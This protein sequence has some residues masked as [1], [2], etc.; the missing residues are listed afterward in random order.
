[1][2]GIKGLKEY[3]EKINAK[4]DRSKA[5]FDERF[6]KHPLW[7]LEGASHIMRTEADRDVAKQAERLIE[8]YEKHMAADVEDEARVAYE[9]ELGCSLDTSK[10]EQAIL[11][12]LERM[13]QKNLLTLARSADNR[14]T[15]VSSNVVN[16]C[17]IAAIATFIDDRIWYWK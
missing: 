10:S 14:S 2:E 9:K 7:A 13:L 8:I 6:E 4:A 5:A 17:K 1:M 12:Y 3:I 15:S 16:D 11:D